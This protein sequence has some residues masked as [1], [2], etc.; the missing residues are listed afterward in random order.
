MQV[1]RAKRHFDAKAKYF[2]M[3]HAGTY[4]SCLHRDMH[5]ILVQLICVHAHFSGHTYVGRLASLDTYVLTYSCTY[6]PASS[7]PYVAQHPLL[8]IDRTYTYWSI[9]GRPASAH[10]YATIQTCLNV[11]IQMDFDQDAYMKK[12]AA[13]SC[14]ARLERNR[15]DS[16]YP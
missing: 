10:V 6:I 16:I 7:H 15:P 8:C 3:A 11:L 4:L 2:C 5:E 12:K 13:C 14:A 9:C 1:T